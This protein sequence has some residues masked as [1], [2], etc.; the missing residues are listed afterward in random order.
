MRIW[1]IS[2]LALILVVTASGCGKKKE[3]GTGTSA[4]LGATTSV[5]PSA[6]A[7]AATSTGG[8]GEGTAAAS[9]ATGAAASA[10]PNNEP[11]PVISRKQLDDLA[12]DSTYDDVVKIVGSKGKMI[13]EENGKKTYEFAL[14]DEPNYFAQIVFFADGKISEKKIYMK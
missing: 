12:I 2:V 10:T 11:P 3:E 9:P 5:Q 8:N 1:M 13:K 7:P 14:K 6:G 4:S